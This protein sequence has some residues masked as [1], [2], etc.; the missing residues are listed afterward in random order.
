MDSLL[1]QDPTVL[2]IITPT[3]TSQVQTLR[4]TN[5]GTSTVAMSIT[6]NSEQIG[7]AHV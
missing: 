2:A 1:P 4:T 5:V 6:V 7:R 3:Y